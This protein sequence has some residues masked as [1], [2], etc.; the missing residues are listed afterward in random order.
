VIQCDVLQVTIHLNTKPSQKSCLPVL[1]SWRPELDSNPFTAG[2][3]TGMK[4]LTLGVG[5]DGIR[6]GLGKFHL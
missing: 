5:L 6:L 4:R 1:Y 2:L 3:G